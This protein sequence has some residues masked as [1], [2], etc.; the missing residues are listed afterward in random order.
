M[1]ATEVDHVVAY[2]HYHPTSTRH[3]PTKVLHCAWQQDMILFSGLACN[4][5]VHD[6][7]HVMHEMWNMQNLA[8]P[9]SRRTYA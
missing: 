3:L 9:F 5:I 4:Q 1:P 8:V 6:L 2:N 7:A